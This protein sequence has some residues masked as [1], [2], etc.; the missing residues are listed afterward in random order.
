[1]LVDASRRDYW[2]S[3]QCLPSRLVAWFA[4][5]DARQTVD[6]MSPSISA[7]NRNERSEKIRPRS[8]VMIEAG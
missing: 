5:L 8:L 6:V 7:S 4:A 1:M 2:R 3:R